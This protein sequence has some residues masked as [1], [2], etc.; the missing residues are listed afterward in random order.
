MEP[1][2]FSNAYYV[3]LGRKGEWEEASIAGNIIR[4]GWPEQALEDINQGNLEI[5]EKRLQQKIADKG[6]VVKDLNA[7]KRIAE[8]TPDDVW[9]IFHSS[10]LWWCR[11]GQQEVFEDGISKYR[12]VACRWRN[13][14]INR[15]PL[16]IS[17]IPG[18]LSKIQRFA[19]T[20][21]RVHEI[22][23]LR[24]LLND[25]PSEAFQTISDAKEALAA[26][27]Q[28][29]LK[30]LHWK[31]F[32]TLTDLIF[33]N[34]GWRRISLLGETMKYVDIEL[35]E[36][37]TGDLYQVQVK[38]TAT[39]SDFEDYAKRFSQTDFRRLY[40]VVHSPQGDWSDYQGVASVDKVEPLLP[41]RLAEM[42]IEFGLLNWL[43]KKI[44]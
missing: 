23:D 17:R 35:E 10:R 41:G 18:R 39:V 42:V 13:H 8:S 4:I 12:K 7:L 34:A 11:V 33:R 30:L 31:D 20:I 44:K 27:V 40:F 9:I 2:E 25:Q 14:D 21:C 38:S 5:V 36:P 3:K 15:N 28:K 22:D 37:V 43:M 26:E 29:G 16:I 1:I 32:E 24:R 6:E 19:G